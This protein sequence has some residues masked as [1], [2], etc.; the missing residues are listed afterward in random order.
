M[1]EIITLQDGLYTFELPSLPPENE[2]WYY[3]VPKKQQ[4][5]KTPHAKNFRWL[6][7]RGEIRDVKRMN[8]RD[9]I[10]YIEYWRDKW[11]NGLWFM[12]N[13]LPTY[14]TGMHVDHLVFNKVDNNYLYFLEAQKERFYFRDLTNKD[15]ICDGRCWIKGRRTGI[16]TEQRTEAIRCIL[17]D[18]SNKVGMQSTKLEICQR[19]LMKPIID[20][21]IGRSPW[22]REEFYKSNGKKPIKAL[23][24]TSSVLREEDEPLGGFIMPFPTVSS[25]L[26]GDGWMLIVMDELSKWLTALPYETLE[27]NLKAIINPRKRGKIDALSTTGDSK[28]AVNS[29]MD[30]HKL[31]ANSNPNLRNANGK[32]TSGLYKYFVSGIHSLDLVEEKPEILD[33]YGFVNKEMAEEYLW[34]NVKKY[35]KDSKEY[36]FALYKTPMEE[37]HALLSS[38]GQGY[39]SKIKI[40]HRLEELRG[41]PFDSKPYVMGSLEYMPNGNVY[42]E[43]NAERQ[44]RCEEDGT[45]YKQGYWAIAL[46]PYVS[47]EKNIDTRNR[48]RVIN[49][50]FFAP[51][52]QEFAFG[53]DPVRYNKEDTS[54]NNLSKA[55]II[56]AKKFDYFGAGDANRY[57]ALYLHRPDDPNDATKECIKAAKYYG[58]SGQHERVIETVKTEFTEA[59]CL[60]LLM[61]N[62]K[63]DLYGMWIDSQGKVVKNALD[64]MVTKFSPPKTEEDIDQIAEMPF[65]DCLTDMDM[66]DIGNTTRFDVFMAMVELEHAL[67]QLNFTNVSDNS[68]MTKLSVAREIFGVRN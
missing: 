15:R 45:I 50:V 51:N 49:G 63:D 64:W 65:E 28:E 61:K 29:V 26:D 2:I 41:M 53:Y 42:F 62:P 56:V 16:T 27:I 13:G 40:A 52:N 36:V 4:Y 25:A 24:L 35:P 20:T 44:K 9:R 60:P 18:Y 46:H 14:I 47:V 58:M 37:R 59:N 31:I 17:S 32:T 21:Y 30:W 55:A 43:S 19:T 39:F 54:S 6:N 10:E 48:F 5:W 66:F 68:D 3:D 22:M 12:N 33:Q 67:K 23:S 34:N 57:A 7:E 1:G 8:E 11:E 38:T